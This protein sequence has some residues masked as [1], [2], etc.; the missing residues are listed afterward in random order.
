VRLVSI[1]AWGGAMYGRFAAWLPQITPDVLCVQEVT[2][3]HGHTGW[4][5][6]DDGDH[7]LPQ[8]A[9]LL[10]D[11]RGLLPRHHAF[12]A[13][14][15]AGPVR[16]ATG[17]DHQQEFGVGTFV[18]ESISVTDVVTRFVHDQFTRHERWPSTGRPRN[19]LATR[20]ALR[21]RS[22]AIT[23]VQVHGLRDAE[24]KHDT[25]ARRAQAERLAAL[26]T[27]V[28][29]PGDAVVLCG[30]LNLL[31]NSE[32]FD[33]LREAGLVDLV[34]TADTR[35]SRY[36]K[37]VRHAS[38]LLVSDPAAVRR[39]EVLTEPEVSDHRALLLEL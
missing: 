15:D 24:G 8:R 31:P 18:H 14:G 11:I 27:D 7:A 5:A 34:G 25:P 4:T 12:F 38:Y 13:A 22:R 1:N 10:A 23:V 6:F 20:L 39:F 16:D 36:V 3:T 35:G 32:T 21:G 33:V 30:D 28:R 9:D 2:H 37:P 19:A 26:V 17:V 29:G